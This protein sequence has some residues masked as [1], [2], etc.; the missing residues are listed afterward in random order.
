MTIKLLK[1][2]VSQ[3][4]YIIEGLINQRSTLCTCIRAD[5]FPKIC[6][7]LLM[8]KFKS[9]HVFMKLP[10]LLILK[11][12]LV[13]LFRD[14]TATILTLRMHKEVVQWP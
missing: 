14:P 11:I 13:T 1:G 5:G 3:N 6:I 9:L 8:K 7:D 12:L 2:I 4:K 10:Y